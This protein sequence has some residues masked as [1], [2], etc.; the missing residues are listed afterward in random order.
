M[1]KA[2][3]VM[4]QGGSMLNDWILKRDHVTVNGLVMLALSTALFTTEPLLTNPRL[5]S[6][7]YGLDVALSGLALLVVSSHLGYLAK[8]SS[9]GQIGLY[10]LLTEFLM[11]CWLLLWIARSVPLDLRL[12][13]VLAGWHGVFWGLWLLKLAH[14]LRSSPVRAAIVSIFA[15]TTSAIGMILSTQASLTRPTAVTLISCYTMYI[16]VSILTIDLLLYRTI[17]ATETLPATHIVPLDRRA[18]LVTT[19]GD[20]RNSEKQISGYFNI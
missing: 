3:I 10:L 8:R 14:Q 11:G 18:V 13:L 4:I 12:L 9:R 6:F 15:A 16:G 17:E 19:S 7:G 2:A 5:Q 20:L 1:Q